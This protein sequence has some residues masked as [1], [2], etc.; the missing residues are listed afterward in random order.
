MKRERNVR[1][2]GIDLVVICTRF[3]HVANSLSVCNCIIGGRVYRVVIRHARS[4]NSLYKYRRV[5]Y[6]I[7]IVYIADIIFV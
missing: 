1:F 6:Y 5:G 2:K 4:N 7:I 3:T